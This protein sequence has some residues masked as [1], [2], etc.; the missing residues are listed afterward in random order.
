M[1][2]IKPGVSFAIIAPAGYRILAALKAAGERLDLDLTITS[3][4]DGVHSGPTDP[5]HTGEAY[6]VRTHDLGDATQSVL[7]A[8]LEQIGASFF[9]FLEDPGTPNEHLHFQRRKGLVYTVE[10][11]FA[12]R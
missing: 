11:F 8:V 4:C 7:E 10:D 9:G 12:G 5:H 1:I 2:Q 6:D 3:G